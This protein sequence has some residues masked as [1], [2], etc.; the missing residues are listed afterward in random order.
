MIE[1][2][3]EV[4]KAASWLPRVG[5]LEVLCLGVWEG[6]SSSGFRK[7]RQCIVPEIMDV[8]SSIN[9]GVPTL[10]VHMPRQ[11]AS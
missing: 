11:R 4:K 3:K 2:S 1:C 10:F 8:D 7:V 9:D 6:D 5:L